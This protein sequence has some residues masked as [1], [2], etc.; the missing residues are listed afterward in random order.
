MNITC[1]ISDTIEEQIKEIGCILECSKNIDNCIIVFPVSINFK[2]NVKSSSDINIIPDDDFLLLE[3]KI[4][5][6][7]TLDDIYE[8]LSDDT[9]YKLINMLYFDEN[10][11]YDAYNLLNNIKEYYDDDNDDNYICLNISKIKCL[12]NYYR[13]S[14]KNFGIDKKII[15]FSK[16]NDKWYNNNKDNYKY[17]INFECDNEIVNLIVMTLIDNQIVDD[18]L[19]GL[20]GLF[21]G[22]NKKKV[23]K[24]IELNYTYD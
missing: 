16:D 18:S 24:Y 8:Y 23:Y 21:L 22:T 20:W 15:V 1:N 9:K 3:T 2:I 14:I 19:I 10:L 4:I 6:T 5:N 13:D 12:N 7:T 11:M 17:I